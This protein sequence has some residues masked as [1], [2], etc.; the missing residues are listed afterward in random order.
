MPTSM[1]ELLNELERILN[2]VALLKAADAVKLLCVS[3]LVIGPLLYT[4]PLPMQEISTQ[5]RD[6]IVSFGERLSVRAFSAAFNHSKGEED[7]GHGTSSRQH[8][9][10]IHTLSS[11]MQAELISFDHTNM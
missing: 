9:L 6:R 7:S 10:S 4:T 1:N 11:V 5:T 8:G 3:S 2:G